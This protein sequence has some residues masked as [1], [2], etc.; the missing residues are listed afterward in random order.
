MAWAGT[1]GSPPRTQQK[2]SCW[3]PIKGKVFFRLTISLMQTWQPTLGELAHS[4]DVIQQFRMCCFSAGWFF[5]SPNSIWSFT[6]P[7][8]FLLG[9]SEDFGEGNQSSEAG[10][11]HAW[12]LGEEQAA[13][14]WMVLIRALWWS[15]FCCGISHSLP[16]VTVFFFLP[17]ASSDGV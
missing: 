9:N 10:A 11:G 13:P 1:A 5:F 8:V 2:L 7:S 6:Y 17:S 15:L 16:N 4:C 14:P 3:K 12:Q